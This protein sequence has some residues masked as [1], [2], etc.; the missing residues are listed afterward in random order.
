MEDLYESKA[1]LLIGNDPT[2]QNPLV[3]WQIRSGIR[4]RNSKLFII[5]SADIKLKRKATSVRQSS[6]RH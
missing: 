1:V 2:E 4:H 6:G 5:N 3:A